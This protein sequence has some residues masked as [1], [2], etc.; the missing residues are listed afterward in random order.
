MTTTTYTARPVHFDNDPAEGV[1]HHL[2]VNDRG[3]I[4][5]AIYPS[6][7]GRFLPEPW[8]APSSHLTPARTLG[9]ALRVVVATHQDHHA[10]GLAALPA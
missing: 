6:K 8:H 10:P 9:R 2:V 5:G 3:H 4:L 1:S 7:G